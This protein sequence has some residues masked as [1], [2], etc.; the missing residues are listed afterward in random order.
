MSSLKRLRR[1]GV[2]QEIMN[3]PQKTEEWLKAEDE[4]DRQKGIEAK[5]KRAARKVGQNNTTEA[6]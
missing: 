2:P 3:S 6:E 4:K 1:L 5:A